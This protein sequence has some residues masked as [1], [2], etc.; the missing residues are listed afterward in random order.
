[1]TREKYLFPPEEQ[2][3]KDK[4]D[5]E[6]FCSAALRDVL[7]MPLYDEDEGPSQYQD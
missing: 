6:P 1:M 7:A 4:Q 3:L 5:R 2:V